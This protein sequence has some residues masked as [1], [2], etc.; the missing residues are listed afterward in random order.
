MGPVQPF[1]VPRRGGGGLASQ[2]GCAH[3]PPS[4]G[5]SAVAPAPWWRARRSPRPGRGAPTRWR[6]GA[7]PA[8]RTEAAGQRRRRAAPGAAPGA[9]A[10]LVGEVDLLLPVGL[11]TD[12]A[13]LR[14][15][16]QRLHHG[17]QDDRR[18][19][20]RGRAPPRP[21]PA[22]LTALPSP[23]S[24]CRF[25]KASWA[26]YGRFCSRRY[27]SRMAAAAPPAGQPAGHRGH[28]GPRR[29]GGSRPAPAHSLTA[30]R[31]ALTAFAHPPPPFAPLRSRPAALTHFR[32]AARSPPIGAREEK[33][34]PIGPGPRLEATPRVG[35]AP[36]EQ[37]AVPGPVPQR[38]AVPPDPEE[39]GVPGLGQAG[40]PWGEAGA[41]ERRANGQ[42]R[43]RA[44]APPG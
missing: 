27:R 28:P 17:L 2:A 13:L 5:S 3:P 31:G 11:L 22:P 36:R 38:P 10:H 14:Q 37:W 39:R 7:A 8:A 23:C 32:R 44:S 40:P 34:A 24:R 29:E 21:G 35:G 1:P 20:G 42:G 33:R 9:G 4:A 19:P 6:P 41:R 43:T 12:V 15:L 16:L 30:P 26:L 25:P 18:Q